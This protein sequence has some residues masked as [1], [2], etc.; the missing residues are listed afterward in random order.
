MAAATGSIVV[1]VGM[2]LLLVGAVLASIGLRV[3]GPFVGAAVATFGAAA[4]FAGLHSV[5]T[6]RHR[7]GAPIHG[8]ELA[9][10][11]SGTAAALFG[12]TFIVPG[13]VMIAAGIGSA[14]GLAD[15]VGTWVVAHPGPVVMA[16]G[17]WACLGGLGSVIS[18]WTYR[19]ASTAW[20]QRVP[21]QLVGVL[22][23]GLGLGAIGLGRALA[24]D[25]GNPREALGRIAERIAK[26]LAGGG[27]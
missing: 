11:H 20:W 3:G 9:R 23:I 22:V 24:A 8:S 21:G 25:P 10:D 26:L 7:T 1:K 15:G 14:L 13:V 27:G 5:V 12:L 18:R 17:A 6:R 4:T 16:I 19:D 2:V